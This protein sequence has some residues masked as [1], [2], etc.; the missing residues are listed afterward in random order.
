MHKIAENNTDRRAH[1]RINTEVD[2]S[3]VLRN[4]RI[5]NCTIRNYCKGGL[6][7]ECGGHDSAFDRE[8]FPGGAPLRV[9]FKAPG[10]DGIEKRFDV[11][12]HVAHAFENG[13]G[14]S[15]AQDEYAALKAL[16]RVPATRRDESRESHHEQAQESDTKAAT[17]DGVVQLIKEKI[18]HYFQGQFPTLNILVKDT[19]LE[20]ANIATSNQEQEYYLHASVAFRD[21]VDSLRDQCVNGCL[22]TFDDLI[23][24]RQL[25]AE[26]ETLDLSSSDLSLVE[27]NSFEE[28]V[29]VSGLVSATESRLS[30]ELYDLAQ[31]LTKLVGHPVDNENN[32]VSPGV[33][34][35]LFKDGLASLEIDLIAKKI[36]YQC[37]RKTVLD[38]LSV[39]YTELND[40]LSAHGIL[41]EVPHKI[42]RSEPPPGMATGP[43]HPG[44]DNNS[45]SAMAPPAPAIQPGTPLPAGFTPQITVPRTADNA[46]IAELNE[47]T[48]AQYVGP[49][50]ILEWVPAL[51]DEGGVSGNLAARLLQQV[52]QANTTGTSPVVLEKNVQRSLEITDSLLRSFMSNDKLPAAVRNSVAKLELPLL[53]TALKEPDFFTDTSHPARRVLDALDR[54]AAPLNSSLTYDPRAQEVTDVLKTLTKQFENPHGDHHEDLFSDVEATLES[55]AKQQDE[56]FDISVQRVI[57][58]CEGEN[59]L[60]QAKHR[61]AMLLYEKIGAHEIPLI[62]ANLLSLGWASLLVLTLLK[63]GEESEEWNQYTEVIDRLLGWLDESMAT[64]PSQ[65]DAVSATLETIRNGVARTPV[66][67]VKIK[68]TLNPLEKALL[69]NDTLFQ[70][71]KSKRIRL[72]ET[73]INTIV[74]YTPAVR[75]KDLDRKTYAPH[76]STIRHLQL[77]DWVEERLPHGKTQTLQLVWMSDD[78]SRFVFVNSNGHKILDQDAAELADA[79][80]EK[81]LALVEDGNLPL[82]ERSFQQVLGQKFDATSSQLKKD[83]IT[84]LLNRRAFE[85]RLADTLKN[86]WQDQSQHVLIILELDQFRM[87]TDACGH[88]AAESLLHDIAG[89]LQTFNTSNAA[90][91]HLGVGEFCVLL[92]DATKKEGI[93]FAESERMAINNYIFRWGE[94]QF[95]ISASIGLA[96]MDENIEDVQSIMRN[97]TSAAFIAK[98]NGGNRIKLYDPDDVE[99]ERHRLL[100]TSVT[101]IDDAFE[102]DRLQLFLQPIVPI[103]ETS[104]LSP[105]YEVLLRV[106][107]ED[108]RPLPPGE[109]IEAAEYYNKMQTLDRWVI[110]KLFEWLDQHESLHE[111]L[112]G[113]SLNLSGQSIGDPAILDFILALLRKTT[114]PLEKI[115]FEITET[116][117][118]VHQAN[119]R[120][121]IE[122][123]QKEGCQFYLDDFGTGLSSYAYLKSYPVD[124]IKIDGSFIRHILEDKTDQEMVKSITEIGHFM[125]KHVIAEFVENDEVLRMLGQFGVDYAQGW[126]VG[127]PFPLSDIVTSH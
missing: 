100:T 86:C 61:V 49:D 126:G 15:F 63:E 12:V 24:N 41:E 14:C 91:G 101:K 16:A 76:I 11:L 124:C 48:S 114:F 7:L 31:R 13:L 20:K 66:N 84:G 115:A 9:H 111:S 88:S 108:G 94:H 74:Q 93:K 59:R 118:I 96:I 2:A 82:V 121:F 106:L 54:L 21:N 46:A 28:W 112:G 38:G 62:T 22:H 35:W 25:P 122:T 37:F 4:E 120:T 55:M 95:N 50:Q 79:L 34:S 57:K 97:S 53:H 8:E 18:R 80:K 110:T 32:P 67:P 87:I 90:L 56:S 6:Y 105:H 78:A 70:L 1:R 72:N 60:H 103:S 58:S 5:L 71:L 42:S 109:F 92:E 36:I 116:A 123:I 75:L 77:E 65:S 113:F 119:A 52:Q 102:N 89:V 107:S 127:K 33:I 26:A 10:D 27:D 98:E 117:N 30:E 85:E 3:V 73:Q 40:T 68:R 23:E 17:R 83:H 81:R 39:L 29:F 69:G 44:S 47:E 19:L 125:K 43:Q 45:S 99:M 64:P 51:Q 104:G